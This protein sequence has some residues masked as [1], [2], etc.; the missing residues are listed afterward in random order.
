MTT[1]EPSDSG[2]LPLSS[3]L[4]SPESEVLEFKRTVPRA[5]DL[6]RLLA[7]FANSRG[8][9]MVLGFDERNRSVHEVEQEAVHR[10]LEE[11]QS[12]LDQ[13][14][15]TRL[16]FTETGGSKLA[17]LEIDRSS[18]PIAAEGG[19]YIRRGEITGPMEASEVRNAIALSQENPTQQTDRLIAAVATQTKVVEEL[20]RD[21][22]KAN[23][24]R[25]KGA[26]AFVGGAAGLL[27]KWLFSIGFDALQRAF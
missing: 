17:I 12:R 25:I 23:S 14:V 19:Y 20:R 5:A 3:L 22:D 18:T 26:I 13:R 8:G 7:A 9:T 2:K 4:A 15:R 21:F 10:T 6:A 1:P 27:G 24:L 16:S 11:A